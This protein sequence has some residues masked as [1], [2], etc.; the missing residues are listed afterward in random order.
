[1]REMLPSV[2]AA[3]MVLSSKLEQLPESELW[4]PGAELWFFFPNLNSF[5]K[6]FEDSLLRGFSNASW[7]CSAEADVSQSGTRAL[8]LPEPI[9]LV[10]C[11]TGD[12]VPL[13]SKLLV[14][15]SSSDVAL[16]KGA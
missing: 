2:E 8:E 6:P 11:S 1:M 7:I 16:A 5:L 10:S 12:T 4:S 14:A 9:K 15:G 13:H 3:G